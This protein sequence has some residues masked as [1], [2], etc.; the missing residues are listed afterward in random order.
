[1]VLQA[2]EMVLQASKMVLQASEGTNITITVNAV[3]LAR[4]VMMR[5][6]NMLFLAG[7]SP[8]VRSYKV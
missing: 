5:C 2:S 7:T 1:M 6:V 4:T 3:G 8:S